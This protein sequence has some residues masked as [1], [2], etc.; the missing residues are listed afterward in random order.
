MRIWQDDEAISFRA[1]L[2]LLAEDDGFASW[3][4]ELL[5]GV[6]YDA[7]F[8]E[9]PP[10]C[11]AN[12]DIEAEFVLIDSPVLARLGPDPV[13]FSS[14]FEGGGEIVVFSSLGGDAVLIAPTP[15]EPLAC[16]AHLAAFVREGPRAQVDA[17][18]RKTGRTV[19][20]SIT[21]R[22]LW[23]STSGLGVAWLHVRLDSYPKYYQY[24]PYR[25]THKAFG[26]R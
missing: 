11:N 7:F 20:E 1:Y 26:L 2:D 23:L 4:S 25:E 3:Y 9:H 10:I 8:W 16:C 24:L 12:I 22:N 17:L 13:P 15:A 18:W 5:A 14:Y 21:E 6:Q 19:R